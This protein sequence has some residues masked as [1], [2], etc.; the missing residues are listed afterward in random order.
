MDTGSATTAQAVAA[1]TE[2]PSIEWKPNY[3]SSGKDRQINIY[4]NFEEISN[5][6]IEEANHF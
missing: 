1:C 5:I 2:L 4:I 3:S 6:N